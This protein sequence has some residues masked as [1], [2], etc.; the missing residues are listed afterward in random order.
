MYSKNNYKHNNSSS[1]RAANTIIPAGM[2]FQCI[3]LSLIYTNIPF[4]VQFDLSLMLM[5]TLLVSIITRS[6]CT[7]P[8]YS[9][10]Y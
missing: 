10:F 2:H 5:H 3:A 7:Q 4:T 8:R 6:V 1:E 9:I